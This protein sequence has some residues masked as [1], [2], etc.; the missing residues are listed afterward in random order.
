MWADRVLQSAM[1]DQARR[2]G[3]PEE[4]L[5][6]ISAAWRTWAARPDGWI[7]VL[8]GELLCTA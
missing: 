5:E 2:S 8:H 1:A 4:T 6:R 7:S 3:V